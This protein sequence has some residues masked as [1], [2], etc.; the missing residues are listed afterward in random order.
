MT[1]ATRPTYGNFRRP[2]SAGIG[3]FG[4]VGTVLIF[5][6]I[7]G[8]I[9]L[10]VARAWPLMILWVPCILI[11]LAL[12]AARDRFER[13][14]LV[15]IANRVAWW[16]RK[17]NLDHLY[18][19]GPLGRVEAGKYHLPGI[20]AASE[21]TEHLDS[22]GRPFT[23]LHTPATGHYSVTFS[24]TPDGAALV[25]PE[26]VDSW[27]AEWGAWLGQLSQEAGVVAASVTVETAPDTGARLRREVAGQLDPNAP[28]L[29]RAMLEQ[30]LVDY[31]AGSA[32]TRVW[33]AL[34]FADR[35]YTGRKRSIDEIARDLG[36]RLPTLTQQLG[37]AGAGSCR[38]LSASSVCEVVRTAYDPASS[39]I[40]DDVREDGSDPAISWDQVGPVAT[41]ASWETYRHDSAVSQTWV[42]ATAPRSDV[43]NDVL[44]RL[45]DPHPEVA[46]K[47]VTIIY[48]PLHA[49]KSAQLVEQDKRNADFRVVSAKR[50]SARAL[51][52]QVS[53]E[54]TAREEARGAAL[55]DFALLITA[56]VADESA[57]PDARATIENL[58]ASARL[59]IRPAHGAQDSAFAAG[60]P[61]GLVLQSHMRVP[62]ELRK[63][64]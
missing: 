45:L 19:G 4:L 40:F 23:L 55:V 37:A 6:G 28:E 21:L 53:A 56:T 46:R 38:P 60:L 33:V 42:M 64:L 24:A 18:Q 39:T 22:Y 7:L 1:T 47:R 12:L 30:V 57:L 44:K 16:R 50:P 3:P 10:M 63:A 58:A 9:M 51:R 29:A 49:G 14:A 41:E 54:A 13:P 5:A 59:V 35:T 61:L 15:R 32:A 25:D 31:P 34:T 62:Y 17:A 27:V 20:L 43:A 8:L 36:A 11:L 48:R 26:T 52:A 2:T